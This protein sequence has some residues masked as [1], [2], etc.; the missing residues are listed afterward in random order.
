MTRE[1]KVKQDLSGRFAF[2]ENKISVPRQRRISVEVEYAQFTSVFE[3]IVR[4][5]GFTVLCAIT[6][7]DEGRIFAIIYHLAGEGGAVL[8]LKTGVPRDNPVIR[9]ITGYFSGAEI[10]EREMVDLLGIKV[11]GLKDGKRYPLPD[12][13]PNG[14]YPLRKDFDPAKLKKENK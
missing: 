6:G 12:D 8:N 14:Q 1:E 9:S 11:E 4:E 3:Y 10:Y 5:A 7:I 2:L 13:W